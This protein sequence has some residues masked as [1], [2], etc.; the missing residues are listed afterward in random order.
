MPTI[1][2]EPFPDFIIGTQD[3]RTAHPKLCQAAQASLVRH[4]IFDVA[5]NDPFKGGHLTRWFGK[6][7]DGVHGIQLEMSQDLY[8]ADGTTNIDQAKWDRLQQVL[9]ALLSDL[10]LA[11]EEINEGP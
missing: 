3:G 7:S 4:G 8:L 11:L 10:L 2:Q 1:R 9:T 6:P 5:Y